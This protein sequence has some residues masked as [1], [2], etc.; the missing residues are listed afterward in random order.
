MIKEL[1]NHMYLFKDA[2]ICE[3][4]TDQSTID[5][6]IELCDLQPQKHCSQVKI[7]V[8]R[9]VPEKKCRKAEKE[10]CNTQ[11]VNPHDVKK[12]VFIKYCTKKEKIKSSNS[13][14]PPAPPS[15]KVN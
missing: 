1:Y 9:L 7:A 15:Y 12:P 13:Y 11:L 5:E 4:S 14:L 2:E 3:I 8:P 6:P 10:I